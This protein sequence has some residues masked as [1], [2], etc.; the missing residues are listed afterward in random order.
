MESHV[1]RISA[2]LATTAVLAPLVVASSALPAA[3]S[4]PSVTVHMTGR[5]GHHATGQVW[6]ENLSTFGIYSGSADHAIS[7]PRGQYAV[8]GD[9][10]ENTTTTT[11]AVVVGI[12]GATIVSLDAR[13]GKAVNVGLDLPNAGS[14]DRTVNAVICGGQQGMGPEISGAPGTVF[15]IPN[16]SSKLQFGYLGSWRSGSGNYVVTGRSTSGVPARPGGSFHRSG[17]ARLDIQ[18]RT[19]TDLET[20]GQ[21]V[22]QPQL[23]NVT[24]GSGMWGDLGSF[25]L[26]TTTTAYVSPGTWS[27]RLDANPNVGEMSADRTLLAGGHYYQ[28]FNQ[29]VWGPYQAVPQAWYNRLSFDGGSLIADPTPGV[30]SFQLTSGSYR[31]SENGKLLHQQTISQY[32]G[33]ESF[34]THVTRSGWFDLTVSAHRYYPNTTYPSSILS[35]AVDLH[36]HFW[37]NPSVNQIAPVYSTRFFPAG[38]NGAN[39]AAPGSVTAVRVVPDQL[40]GEVNVV[41]SPNDPPT[42]VKVWASANGGVTWQAVTVKRVNGSWIAYVPNHASGAVSLRSQVTDAHGNYTVESVYRAYAI[43]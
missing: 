7:L 42:S 30:T 32:G 25:S 19:G 11:G 10:Q 8:I 5:N 35:S 20:D 4:G 37:L 27:S 22:L 33:Y 9:V 21:L 43:A 15:V 18:A 36:E 2:L 23:P 39:Q 16:A 6:V 3:A 24:C 26:P 14:Y 38:L 29:A 1:R 31:L 13:R 34:D 28:T 41:K 40:P 12:S 17:L